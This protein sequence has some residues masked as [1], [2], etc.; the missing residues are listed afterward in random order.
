LATRAE[1]LLALPVLDSLLRTENPV[2]KPGEWEKLPSANNIG[3]CTLTGW[4]TITTNTT[5][6]LVWVK[7]TFTNPCAVKIS[8]PV[9]PPAA[10]YGYD[11][12][13][14]YGGTA[15]VNAYILR[16]AFGTLW[17]AGLEINGS[18]VAEGEI[19]AAQTNDQYAVSWDEG[20]ANGFKL[21]RIRAG[22]M[23]DLLSATATKGLNVGTRAA[24]DAFHGGTN[25]TGRMSDF[26]AGMLIAPILP[27]VASCQ[28]DTSLS[29]KIRN[30]LTLSAAPSVSDT[31]LALRPGRP[32]SLS[33]SPGT[34]DSSL[35]LQAKSRIVPQTAVAQSDSSLE[36]TVGMKLSP[37]AA[38]CT[39]S[40]SVALSARTGL[41]LGTSTASSTATLA[42]K[43][44]RELH[45][46]SAGGQTNTTLVLK[47]KNLLI[48]AP[49]GGMSSTTMSITRS[50][51][52]GTYVK[53]GG[54][55]LPI[56]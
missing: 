26:A 4:R 8:W 19:P 14:L 28:S 35:S 51:A 11:I 34:T 33:S 1:K 27:S 49:A 24:I 40:S 45:L 9:V 23:T 6:G 52:A 7:Q 56:A 54:I 2:N 43:I 20:E 47:R 39:S 25:V 10:N 5:A 50:F 12:Y 22:V 37:S 30:R 21:S 29:L 41:A 3:Q 15:P 32:L 55:W 13:I 48:F 18:A 53:L 42:L 17:Y 38:Q 36:L 16:T 31:T 46:E 44:K